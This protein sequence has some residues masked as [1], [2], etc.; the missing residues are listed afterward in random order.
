MQA[1]RYASDTV[2]LFVNKMKIDHFLSYQIAADMYEPADAFHLELANPETDIN[3]GHLCELLINGQKELTGLIDKVTRTINKN[4]TSLIVEGRDLMGLLIDSHIEPPYFNIQNMRLQALA[5]RLLAKVPFIQRKSIRYQDSVNQ[6]KKGA[7]N[8]GYVSALD[9]QQKIGQIEA[10][11]TIF[12]VLKNYSLSRG[13][14]F[15]CL[16]DGTLVFGRPLVKGTPEYKLQMMSSGTGNNVIE[17]DVMQDISKRYSKVIVIGQQQGAESIASTSISTSN[18]SNPATDTSF[19]FAKVYVEKDN[20]D[21][22]S[23][24]MRAR[25]IME[26][27]RRE[28]TQLLYTVGRHAQNNQNWQINK[29]CQIKDDKQT[30]KGKK[31]IDGDY[32]IYGRTFEMDKQTGPITKLKLGEPGVV[33]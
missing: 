14:L 21:D 18:V 30:L 15:Y 20:N 4:G 5:E 9:T 11:M 31:G 13:L 2:E 10:G 17:S 33:A 26:K 3:T 1:D 24:A 12:E 19:P 25:S 28:G 29:F 6:G 7:A 23:P 8:S 32:L 16:P 22:A 27:Q